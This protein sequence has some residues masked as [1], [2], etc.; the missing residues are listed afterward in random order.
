MM[1]EQQFFMFNPKSLKG[2]SNGPPPLPFPLDV[3]ASNLNALTNCQKLWHNCFLIINTCFDINQ[4]TSS[5]TSISD[6]VITESHE[7]LIFIKLCKFFS[8]YWKII[9][10]LHFLSSI[11]HFYHT[12]GYFLS[13]SYNI[14]QFSTKSQKSKFIPKWLPSSFY[15]PWSPW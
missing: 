10:T 1:E 9:V 2:M 6:D 8:K 13:I 4:M 14:S 12:K 5:T 3:L 15:K 7:S 11:L